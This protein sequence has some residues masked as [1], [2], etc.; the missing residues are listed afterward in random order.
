MVPYLKMDFRTLTYTRT[1]SKK[2]I[3][4]ISN[5][6]L[7]HEKCLY[8]YVILF[9][10]L[11]TIHFIHFTD[12]SKCSQVQS[13]ITVCSSPFQSKKWFF[14][15]LF[16]DRHDKVTSVQPLLINNYCRI[17][18]HWYNSDP[19]F[20][21]HIP[22]LILFYVSFNQDGSDVF[23]HNIHS[24]SETSFQFVCTYLVRQSLDRSCDYF[25]L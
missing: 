15:Y 5:H 24:H 10:L 14:Q 17:M 23:I 2:K 11:S 20:S 3:Y 19:S 4:C 22:Y 9:Y 25:V 18:P 13:K 8:Q 12:L 6:N 16:E 1:Q 21:T 7:R